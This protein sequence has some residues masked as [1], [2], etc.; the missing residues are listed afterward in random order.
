MPR[1]FIVDDSIS[2]RKALEITFKRHAL[3]SVSAVSAEDA[4]EVLQASSAP[5][6]LI[7]ADVIM[8][9]MSGLEL[10]STLRQQPQYA[11]IPLVLMSGNIDDE[12]K[13]QAKEVGANGVLRK[14]FS[15]DELIPMVEHLL[16]AQAEAAVPVGSAAQATVAATPRPDATSPQIPT[17]HVAENLTADE[18]ELSDIDLP[19]DID[20]V[21]LVHETAEPLQA[22]QQPLSAQPAPQAVP[23]AAE[24]T[25][26]PTPAPEH[27]PASVQPAAGQNAPQEPSAQ[28]AVPSHPMLRLDPIDAVKGLV[29]QYRSLPAVEDVMVLDPEFRLIYH[30]GTTLAGQLPSYAKYFSTTAR[31]IGQQLLDDEVQTVTLQYSGR[32]V[33][34]HIIHDYSVVVL[35]KN[36]K[37]PN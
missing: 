15:P 29:Q 36:I 10:C 11:R 7:M 22:S 23:E 13:G 5:F 25:H 8:P 3:E 1:I 18:F 26:D 17:D 37:T 28:P 14:P 16:K 30:S 34:Y 12:V 24:V 33:I 35:H 31:I 2:V 19:V 4:L 6:D 21:P 32:S 27:V 20:P 9:G